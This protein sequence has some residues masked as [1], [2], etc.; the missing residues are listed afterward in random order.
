[1]LSDNESQTEFALYP[2]HD[3]AADR[4]SHV[5]AEAY[6]TLEQLRLACANSMTAVGGTVYDLLAFKD[7]CL[8]L[9]PRLP[10]LPAN[11]LLLLT[12]RLY[13]ETGDLARLLQAIFQNIFA[14]GY[15]DDTFHFTDVRL[16]KAEAAAL[17]ADNARLAA[18]RDEAV[19]QF[20]AL[21][22]GLEQHALTVKALEDRNDALELRSS[23][24]E[25]QMALLFSQLADD[26]VFY[27]EGLLERT[28]EREALQSA[29]APARSAFS[30]S[31]D[32]IS[33]RLVG[34]Q[35]TLNEIY[36][37]AKIGALSGGGGGGGGGS[38]PRR[39]GGGVSASPAEG[40][41]SGS[42]GGGT[43]SVKAKL[44]LLDQHAQQMISRFGAVK[45]GLLAT[46]E[47]LVTALRD[48]RR[49]VNFSIQHI[50]LFDVQSSRLRAGRAL[51]HEIR[52]RLTTLERSLA[53]SLLSGT[54]LRI[55]ARTGDIVSLANEP[56]SSSTH[57]ST[58]ATVL[59]QHDRLSATPSAY[60]GSG[61]NNNHNQQ[62]QRHPNAVSNVRTFQA[63]LLELQDAVQK[64]TA[65][66][67]TSAEQKAMLR[68]VALA[69]PSTGRAYGQQPGAAGNNASPATAAAG[70]GNSPAA[71]A[72]RLAAVTTNSA[73]GGAPTDAAELLT[74]LQSQ[75]ARLPAGGGGATSPRTHHGGGLA[76]SGSNGGRGRGG[77]QGTSDAS[78]ATLAMLR[79]LKADFVS[80]LNFVRAVYEG[81]A[82]AYESRISALADTVRRQQV[83][84]AA[85]GSGAAT[86]LPNRGVGGAGS[87]KRNPSPSAGAAL[88]AV[89]RAESAA[90]QAQQHNPAATA[91]A[92]SA[93]RLILPDRDAS[94]ASGAQWAATRRHF[95]S[96]AAAVAVPM[97]AVG[98]ADATEVAKAASVADARRRIGALLDG[99]ESPA[100]AFLATVRTE[101]EELLSGIEMGRRVPAGAIVNRPPPG[102]DDHND[103]EAEADEGGSP[104]DEGGDSPVLMTRARGAT[105]AP[106]HY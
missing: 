24:L 62:Q 18:E 32:A 100:A 39:G 7:V 28:A 55:E 10:A 77:A 51:M 19:R 12:S 63:Q 48:K 41:G 69:T 98:D 81:Q 25:D 35:A 85:Y 86:G 43:V 56:P 15:A 26:F 79:Q 88:L 14:D 29:V 105:H 89:H 99:A 57:A 4:Y 37:D 47:E 106:E 16:L 23:A 45:D 50:K 33:K 46:S 21:S 9:A 6:R 95:A 52:Q 61:N 90:G 101:P 20:E 3:S 70:G 96:A 42:G 67:D 91:A 44:K 22:G 84:L 2:T 102:Y 73:A 92:A 34:F 36:N 97:S 5:H 38:S 80:K 83:Q 58:A 64:V 87:S 40:V 78:P 93:Q 53:Q 72:Q 104:L 66:L 68:I 13:R 103:S 49:I 76:D 75:F 60:Y 82:A 54:A 31:V 65:A 17:R 74:S 8:R 71:A 94:S 1:M 59:G 27:N 30:Q 11:D